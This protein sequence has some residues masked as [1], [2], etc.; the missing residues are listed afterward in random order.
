MVEG[1]QLGREMGRWGKNLQTKQAHNILLLNQ[2][3]NKNRTNRSWMKRRISSL[4]TR[5]IQLAF[6]FFDHNSLQKG[7]E[8]QLQTT[9]KELTVFYKQTYKSSCFL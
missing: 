4:Y 9:R 8:E 5:H 7:K 2:M 3:N 6:S 1:L